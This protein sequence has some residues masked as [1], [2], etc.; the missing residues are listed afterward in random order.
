LCHSVVRVAMCI[1]SLAFMHRTF[2]FLFV[3]EVRKPDLDTI[4]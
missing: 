2:S 3:P 1:M 4:K